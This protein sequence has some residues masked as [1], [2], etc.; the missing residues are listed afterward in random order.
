MKVGDTFAHP[1]FIQGSPKAGTARPDVCTITRIARGTVYY[2]TETGLSMKT[3]VE[4][5][6]S[7]LQAGVLK[8]IPR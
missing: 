8:E 6:T 4:A 3:T 2:R 7:L 5:L 1:R